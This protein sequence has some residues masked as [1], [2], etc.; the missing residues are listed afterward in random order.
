METLRGRCVSCGFLA[1][2]AVPGE[3]LSTYFEVESSERASGEVFSHT[4]DSVRGPVPTMPI[5]FRSAFALGQ[6]VID[7]HQVRDMKGKKEAAQ[8]VFLRDRNCDQWFQYTPGL[9]P[10]QHL[11]GLAMQELEQRQ[12]KFQEMMEERRQKWERQLEHE[13]RR[14]DLFLA[15]IVGGVAV[16]GVVATIV[17]IFFP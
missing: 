7:E 14:F 4:P 12:Y 11:G 13:R 1:K 3:G 9:S 16:A 15:A 6:E 17:G 8:R 2:H 5:C 10:Q